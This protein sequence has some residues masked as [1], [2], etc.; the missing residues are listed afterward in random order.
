MNKN[1][2]TDLLEEKFNGLNGKKRRKEC[3]F[4]QKKPDAMC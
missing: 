1:K 2:K 3:F 4:S